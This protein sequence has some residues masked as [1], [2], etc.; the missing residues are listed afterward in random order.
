MPVWVVG[1][2]PSE[3]SMA[4]AA[5]WD[6]LVPQPLAAP[7]ADAGPWTPDSLAAAIAWVREHRPDHLRDRPYDVT[8]DGR[9]PGDDPTAGARIVRPWAAA[10]ATWWLESDWSPEVTVDALR[11]R[12]AGGPPRMEADGG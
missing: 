2:W 4:R 3:R 9:T 7:G 10:G 1:A 12:I 11:R 5:R 8:I 6:G